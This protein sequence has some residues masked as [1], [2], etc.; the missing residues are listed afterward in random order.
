M[1]GS[2]LVGA[3]IGVSKLWR[4]SRQYRGAFEEQGALAF[5]VGERCST[6][7]L[8]TCLVQAAE[9]GQEVAADAWQEVVTLQRRVRGERVDELQARGRAE[10]HRE[11]DRAVQL[12]D[13]GWREL[14]ER[15][16]ERRDA[17][18]VRLLGGPCPPVT[19]G[20]RGLQRIRAERAPEGLGPLQRGQTAADEQLVPSATIRPSRS[21]S[22]QNA[23][24][25]QSSPAVAA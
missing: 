6:L 19:G 5:V 9:L 13:G 2:F 24:R 3:F 17:R 20:D 12:H 21:A 25:I 22:S 8:L 1:T 4:R 16:V 18:P 7:E 10:R 11:R 15:L 23:G 14:G